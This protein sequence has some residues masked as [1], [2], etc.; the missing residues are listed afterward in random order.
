MGETHAFSPI[1]LDYLQ[2]KESLKNFYTYSPSIAGIHRAAKDR[3]FQQD[4]RQL[5]H[6]RLRAQYEAQSLNHPKVDQS[7]KSLL[8][9]NTFTITT[10]HQLNIFSGPLY[11]IYKIVTVIK[12]AEKLNSQQEDQHFVPVYW[13]A[14]EDHDLDEIRSFFLFGNTYAWE[15]EQEGAVGRMDCSG[16]E[17]IFEALPESLPLFQEAY[18]ATNSL[19]E[20]TRYFVHELFKE[21]GLII[22][23]ADDGALKSAF[24]PH[25]EHELFESGFADEV[26][27]QTEKLEQAGYKSQIHARDINL[28]YLSKKSRER[29]VKIDNRFETVDQSLKWSEDELREELKKNPQAFSPNVV[30]RPLY[31]EV[32]LPNVAYCGGPAEVAYWLQLKPIFDRQR[33]NFPVLLPRNFALVLNKANQK[34]LE[35]T[36]LS[37]KDLFLGDEDLKVKIVKE[38]S[39][40]EVGLGQEMDELQKFWDQ[41]REKINLIDGSLD[42]F[43]GA[44]GNKVQKSLQ[45][46]E[47]RLK[48][49]EEKKQETR[50]N[51]VASLKSKLF[52]SGVLQER[53][54]N[55]LNFYIN[56]PKFINRVYNS[57]DPFHFEFYVLSYV[58]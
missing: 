26:R 30:L 18:Q 40:H 32:I 53:K 20:A 39:E 10:G 43:V 57:L 4:S 11:F 46:I 52:P 33:V 1:F 36:A 55:F 48:K 56:D 22:V 9:S 17:K 45:N 31:Q 13:M 47:K 37:V 7:I 14:S 41:L 3:R 2:E 16:F 23:D 38:F 5:I 8:N 19:A 28:F 12:A 6:D 29:I 24:I 21:Y 27:Q 34:K 49:A 58:H 25:M 54:E 51:Q 50:I 42:G 35:K 44:E 15:R